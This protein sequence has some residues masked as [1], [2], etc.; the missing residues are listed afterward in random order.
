MF[1]KIMSISDDT[2]WTYYQLLLELD[3]NKIERLK[4]GHPMDAKKHL[5]SSLVG[6]F[7]NM[8]EA[9]HALEQ[10]EQVFSKQVA[11]R[12]ADLHLVRS[13]RRYKTPNWSI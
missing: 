10:F 13:R 7:H 5:A 2:M 6:Q 1:G 4:S 11:V 12:Y 3:E 9:K 8:K